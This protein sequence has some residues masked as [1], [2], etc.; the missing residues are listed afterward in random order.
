M[1]SLKFIRPNTVGEIFSKEFENYSDAEDLIE[2]KVERMADRGWNVTELRGSNSKNGRIEC[3]H[4][5][6]ADIFIIKWNTPCPNCGC[7]FELES[8]LDDRK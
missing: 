2:R 7:D 1:L 8:V 6:E 5:N 3:T 4:D